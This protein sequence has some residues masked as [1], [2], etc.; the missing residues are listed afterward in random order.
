LHCVMIFVF[1]HVVPFKLCSGSNSN[2]NGDQAAAVMEELASTYSCNG[3]AFFWV[4]SD[5]ANGDWS[6]IV[7]NTIQANAGCSNAPTVPTMPGPVAPTPTT[8]PISP[9]ATPPT[10]GGIPGNNVRRASFSKH[11]LLTDSNPMASPYTHSAV[12]A[13]KTL[14]NVRYPALKAWTVNA[15]RENHV[16]LMLCARAVRLLLLRLLCNLTRDDTF[17]K[18]ASLVPV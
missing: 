4:S 7:S 15:L 16:L 11:I 5:D 2:A 9:P 14:R 8:T 18:L 12:V 17:Y 3:G 6:N 1:T 13:F 10:S